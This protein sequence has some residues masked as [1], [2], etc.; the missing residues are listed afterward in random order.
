METREPPRYKEGEPPWLHVTEQEA[1]VV[2]MPTTREL[3]VAL[4]FIYGA[5]IRGQN[6]VYHEGVTNRHVFNGA[7]RPYR[8]FHD[9]KIKGSSFIN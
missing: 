6:D 8:L 4:L 1:I 2:T 9:K 5:L 3:A 7:Q